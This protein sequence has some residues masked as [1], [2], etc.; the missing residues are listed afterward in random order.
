MHAISGIIACCILSPC[1]G[2]IMSIISL[3]VLRSP[4]VEEPISQTY[5]ILGSSGRSPWRKIPQSKYYQGPKIPNDSNLTFLFRKLLLFSQASDDYS[6]RM[7]LHQK[8]QTYLHLAK[9][10]LLLS[11]VFTELLRMGQQGGSRCWIL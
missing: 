1:Q 7:M 2:F 11:F 8:L 4:V 5:L 6:Y 9:T 3:K 10:L